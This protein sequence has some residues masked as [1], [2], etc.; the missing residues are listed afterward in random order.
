[1]AIST[2]GLLERPK[3]CESV[4]S[5]RGNSSV[6]GFLLAELGFLVTP[7]SKEEEVLLGEEVFLEPAFCWVNRGSM[8][9]FG[10]RGKCRL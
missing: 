6:V 9:A 10:V 3:A 5:T 2:D 4:S 7:L 1:M 8:E